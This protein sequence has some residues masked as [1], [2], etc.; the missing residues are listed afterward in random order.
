M[1][2]CKICSDIADKTG[3]HIVPHFLM[4]RIDSEDG[5]M[6]RDKEMGFVI[7]EKPSSYFGRATSPEKLT[8]LFGEIDDSRIEN[9][10]I[11]L[12]EDYIFCSR[13]EKELAELESN[14]S[15]SID[16][17]TFSSDRNY[18][19]KI[20]SDKALLFWSSVIYRLSISENSGVRLMPEHEELF[21]KILERFFTAQKLIDDSKSITYKL[22]RAYEYSPKNTTVL[23]FNPFETNPYYIVIDEFIIIFSIDQKP[24]ANK[25]YDVE[26]PVR[27]ATDND[28][29]NKTESIYC[30]DYAVLSQLNQAFFDITAKQYKENLFKECDLVYDKFG[31]G[32]VMPLLMKEEIFKNLTDDEDMV[33]GDKYTKGHKA[34]VIYNVIKKHSSKNEF[35]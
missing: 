21:K 5:K 29:T 23:H 4:K 2:I 13:C 10:R 19:S 3:S 22:F 9:N 18:S 6:G 34:K 26:I 16:K 33:F 7:S 11:P 14:Y 15:K 28:I 27:Q 12:V 17:P 1:K 30:L 24:F 31:F 8:E 32:K 20:T 25:F 35:D